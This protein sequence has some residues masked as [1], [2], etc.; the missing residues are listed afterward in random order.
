V[1]RLLT[2]LSALSLLLCGAAG[3]MWWRSGRHAPLDEDRISWLTSGGDRM[4]LRSDAGRV[5]LFEPPA[6]DREAVAQLPQLPPAMPGLD[7]LP[8]RSAFPDPRF[9]VLE[10][11]PGISLP[12]LKETVAALHGNQVEWFVLM[13]Q[14]DTRP[15]VLGPYYLMQI[16]SPAFLMSAHCV[17]EWGA[18][19]P[20]EP[21]LIGSLPAF[22]SADVIPSL[23]PAL[24]DPQR[25][26]MAHLLLRHLHPQM[27]SMVEN[28]AKRIDGAYRVDGLDVQLSE[29]RLLRGNTSVIVREAVPSIDPAQ[30]PRIRDQWHRRLD[31]AKASAPWWAITATLAGMPL[32]WLAAFVRRALRRRQRQSRGLC[33]VCGYDLRASGG[34]CPECGEAAGAT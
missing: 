34:R 33:R 10:R 9:Q 23:L 30:L 12:T 32:I 27:T 28:D 29:G 2:L 3:A 8:R 14:S 20:R 17:V 21:P 1:R 15:S 13:G 7:P 24:E 6:W 18:V 22:R 19:T 25:F 16:G 11:P 26:A 31:V 5:T 4:T